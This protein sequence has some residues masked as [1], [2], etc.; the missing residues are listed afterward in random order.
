MDNYKKKDL[1]SSPKSVKTISM[2]SNLKDLY[3]KTN[4]EVY[5][6]SRNEYIKSS[7]KVQ[8]LI[9]KY[10]KPFSSTKKLSSTFHAMNP[11]NV[12]YVP[13]SI[14]TKSY[15]DP[16]CF[17]YSSSLRDSYSVSEKSAYFKN[18]NSQLLSSAKSCRDTNNSGLFNSVNLSEKTFTDRPST[19]SSFY[20][21]RSIPTPFNKGLTKGLEVQAC[22]SEP[23]NGRKGDM[24]K[25]N[26]RK[27]NVY[28]IN[29]I[30]EDLHKINDTKEDV[31][32][33]ND[34][35]EDVDKVNSRYEYNTFNVIKDTIKPSYTTQQ[36]WSSPQNGKYVTFSRPSTP[37]KQLSHSLYGPGE[38]L[39]VPLSFKILNTVYSFD[40]NYETTT[41]YIE[42]SSNISWIIKKDLKS[43]L[44]LLDSSILKNKDITKPV[45]DNMIITMLNTA[46]I[47]P[48][49]QYFIL[50]DITKNIIARGEYLLLY[51]IPYIFKLVGKALVSYN[52]HKRVHRI[53]LLEECYIE[54]GENDYC[55]LIRN[56]NE[57]VELYA[58]C[59][60]ERD[61]WVKDINNFIETRL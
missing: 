39:T 4:A 41:Y 47:S 59:K 55:F 40:M 52:M 7:S 12:L 24:Y 57:S 25:I 49:L 35:I 34:R 32:K 18:N 58:S 13:R 16:G 26:D 22:K 61:E 54:D 17:S 53:F 46:K 60:M 38:E 48:S 3:T 29:D 43:I 21:K 31:Y 51:N 19:S 6:F 23:M 9:N 20:N 14:P 44:N 28:K 45:R 37:N 15:N 50:T 56:K 5:D 8:D 36:S 42:I 10:N 27:E 33:I 11:I 30:K 2:K 1:L